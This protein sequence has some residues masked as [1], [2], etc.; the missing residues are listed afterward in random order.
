[1]GDLVRRSRRNA[2][3]AWRARIDDDR[4]HR[5][6]LNR[7]LKYP[8]I[9]MNNRCYFRVIRA[10]EAW[11][12]DRQTSIRRA[13][14]VVR[15]LYRQSTR[16]GW[17]TWRGY[18]DERSSLR[19][20]F[21]RCMYLVQARGWR[22]WVASCD[23]A[24]RRRRLHAWAIGGLQKRH[25]RR[26]LSKWMEADLYDERKRT[27]DLLLRQAPRS[28]QQSDLHKAT[29]TWAGWYRD[30]D[31]WRRHVRTVLVTLGEREISSR[32]EL[33]GSTCVASTTAAPNA[34]AGRWPRRGARC[35]RGSPAIRQQ[36]ASMSSCRGQ[37]ALCGTGVHVVASPNGSNLTCTMSESAR[38]IPCSGKQLHH[39]VIANSS[40]PSTLTQ[41]GGVRPSR[42]S[43]ACETLRMLAG[44]S[45]RRG[46]NSWQH[47]RRINDGCAKCSPLA[48]GSR[49]G[50]RWDVDRLPSGSRAPA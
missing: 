40:V 10:W 17:F 41:S 36:S 50:A 27:L 2:L 5:A 31:E 29:N 39:C 35:G 37:L 18:Y 21:A 12:L 8:V 6:W 32:V 30:R 45:C 46:W 14:A 25:E 23:E 20:M 16:R 28:L 11:L 47:M 34:A 7:Q 1:M 19:R 44:R 26:A 13:N 15:T 42:S 49:R 22:T 43:G 24:H 9:V 3:L 33:L 48:V 38:S 4:E